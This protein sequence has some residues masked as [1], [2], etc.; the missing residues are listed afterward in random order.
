[1]FSLCRRQ[2]VGGHSGTAHNKTN[3]TNLQQATTVGGECKHT[4]G[5]RRRRTV[6]VEE[7]LSVHGVLEPPPPPAH[8]IVV[9]NEHN[10]LLLLLLL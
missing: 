2:Y 7:S 8:G 1:V 10:G 6:A 9:V 5:A 4:H 3:N